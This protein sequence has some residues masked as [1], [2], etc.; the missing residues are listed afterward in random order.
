MIHD[1]GSVSAVA[2][3]YDAV[4]SDRPYRPGWPPTRLL[5]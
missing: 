3:I 5:D 1:F 4:A 2:G